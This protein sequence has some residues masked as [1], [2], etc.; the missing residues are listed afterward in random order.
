MATAKKEPKRVSVEYG[1][2]RK[3]KARELAKNDGGSTAVE[4][5]GMFFVH[6]GDLSEKDAKAMVKSLEQAGFTAHIL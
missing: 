5:D 6:Q 3:L 1:P 4:K 2:F